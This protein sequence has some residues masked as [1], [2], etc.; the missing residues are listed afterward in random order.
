MAKDLNLNLNYELKILRSRFI[1]CAASC[2]SDEQAREI[3][4]Q[5]KLEHKN[6]THNCWGYVINHNNYKSEFSSDNG[7]PP[8]TA[9]RPILGAIKKRGLENIIVIVTRYFG[10]KKLGV[11]GLIEAYGLAA[12]GAIANFNE[13][14]GV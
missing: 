1:A 14:G 5:V 12:D 9:G 7:E 8:G 4:K 2:F 11:R 10:G 3:I 6:A 13:N